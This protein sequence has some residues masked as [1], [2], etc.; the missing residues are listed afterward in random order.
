MSTISA[1]VTVPT[2][3]NLSGDTTG[4]LTFQVSGTVTAATISAAGNFGIGV[5]PGAWDTGNSVKALQVTNAAALWNYSTSNIYLSQN[6]LWN[7]TNRV[8]TVTGSNVAEFSMQNGTFLFHNATSG[9][10]GG[11]VSLTERMRIDTSGNVGI[12]VTPTVN[13]DVKNAGGN[14]TISAQ[15]GTG[16]KGQLIAA[17]NEVQLKAFNGTND[18]LTFATGASERMRISSAGEVNIGSSANYGG[19]LSVNRAQSGGIADLLTLRDSSSG[20]TFNLQAYGDPAAGTANR[21]N[22][23]GAYL[24]FRRG[25]TEQMRLTSGGNALIGTAADL[26]QNARLNILTASGEA[27]VITM[28][29][30][31]AAAG[32]H[33]RIYIDSNST[34]YLANQDNVGVYITDGGNTWNSLSDERLKT[35]LMPIEDSVNKICQLRAVTGRFK[36]DE[37]GTSRSFLIAQDVQKVFPEAVSAINPDELGLR[38]TDMVPLLVAAV[39]ELKAEN[40]AL[41]ARIEALETK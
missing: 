10:V 36:T 17:S 25:T 15:Y 41:K 20:T 30:T 18:V 22:Y 19:L 8:Y 1:G 32:K 21:F 23:G 2:A 12:G 16:T 34:F 13:L 28:R 35:D 9:T 27:D 26:G 5:V 3:L 11:T 40:D 4:A 29:Y 14:C 38:Y 37:E 39:K 33:W 24:A 31:D 6:I 7:G